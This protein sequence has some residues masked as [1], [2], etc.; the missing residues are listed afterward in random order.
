[1][2]TSLRTLS[3]ATLLLLG[4]GLAGCERSARAPEASAPTAPAP[5][6]APASAPAAAVQQDAGGGA[7]SSEQ[8]QDLVQSAQACREGE[9]CALA[10]AGTCTCAQPVN[11]S[12]AAEVDAAAARVECGGAVV[13]CANPGSARCEAG[14]CVGVTP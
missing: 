3:L 13:R 14:K 10:G 11:A 7:M 8:L 9:A 12:R 4:G 5:T 2:K 1:M 6:A